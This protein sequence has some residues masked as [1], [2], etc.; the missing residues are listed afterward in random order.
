LQLVSFAAG[1]VGYAVFF[2]LFVAGVSVSAGLA[3]LI[4]RWVMWSG[5]GLAALGELSSLTLLF[6]EAAYLLPATR[7]LGYAWLICLGAVL[8]KT[9]AA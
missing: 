8:P 2:G 1:G 7:F 3:R 4:P 5:L 6:D 9:R